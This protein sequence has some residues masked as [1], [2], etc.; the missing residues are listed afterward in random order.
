[1][2]TKFETVGFNS[3][4]DLTQNDPYAH[5]NVFRYRIRGVHI[6]LH[7]SMFLYENRTNVH[8][9]VAEECRELD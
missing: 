7:I 9:T 8:E 6:M 3:L 4:D 2:Y 1:M 5:S